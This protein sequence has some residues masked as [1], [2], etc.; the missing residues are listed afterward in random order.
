V[1]KLNAKSATGKVRRKCYTVA[2]GMWT[3]PA[4]DAHCGAN[5]QSQKNTSNPGKCETITWI[6][7]KIYVTT[8]LSTKIIK[9]YSITLHSSAIWYR[10]IFL[11]NHIIRHSMMV[12]LPN[13]MN[14]D[15][16]SSTASCTVRSVL[17]T[18]I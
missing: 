13:H 3:L 5:L 12:V 8:L 1:S 16:N 2:V 14:H 4:Y 9:I 17:T 10:Y 6:R 15:T 18:E 7:T 11:A